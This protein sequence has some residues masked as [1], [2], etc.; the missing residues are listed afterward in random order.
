ML[1]ADKKVKKALEF[2][3]KRDYNVCVRSEPFS[4]PAT[5]EER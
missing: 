2:G 4:D 5:G 3:P 1:N